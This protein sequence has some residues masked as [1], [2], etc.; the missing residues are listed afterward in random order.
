MC[1]CMCCVC[2]WGCLLPT[3]QNAEGRCVKQTVALE[4]LEENEG[5][6]A[7]TEGT[8]VNCKLVQH[9]SAAFVRLYQILY[10][11]HFRGGSVH[12]CHCIFLC[13]THPCPVNR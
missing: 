10:S 4:I 9:V 13:L 3:T 1:V 8:T 6:E 2:V 7:G 11:I 12:E 5:E